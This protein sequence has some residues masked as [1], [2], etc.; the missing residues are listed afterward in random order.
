MMVEDR[1]NQSSREVHLDVSLTQIQED[2]DRFLE[3]ARQ[4]IAQEKEVVRFL[5]ERNELSERIDKLLPILKKH[6]ERHYPIEK[7]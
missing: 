3:Q 5:E 6:I 7:M 1:S 4:M 2:F